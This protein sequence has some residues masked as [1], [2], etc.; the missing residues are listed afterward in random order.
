MKVALTGATGFVGSHALAELHAGLG[1]LP[2]RPGLVD[3][4]RDGSYRH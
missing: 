1:W 2:T 3:E 4:F